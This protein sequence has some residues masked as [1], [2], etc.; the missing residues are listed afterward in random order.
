[1][2]GGLQPGPLSAYLADASENSR[3]DDGLM[4]RFQLA[5]YPDIQIQWFNVDKAPNEDARMQ[6]Y[7]AFGRLAH[8]RPEQLGADTPASGGIPAL[9]FSTEAQ[10]EFDRWRANLEMRLRSGTLTPTLESHLAKFRKLVPTLALLIHVI[11]EGRGPVELTALR[12]AV[13][14]AQFLESHAR[15]IYGLLTSGER[16]TL[17]H[18]GDALLGGVFADGFSARDVYRT[19]RSGLS[20]AKAVAAALQQLVDLGWLRPREKS[21]GG[22]PIITYELNP[23]IQRFRIETSAIGAKGSHDPGQAAPEDGYDEVPKVPEGPLPPD[24]PLRSSSSVTHG[25]LWKEE[26]Q[27]PG[28]DNEFGFL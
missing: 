3:L 23:D 6:A 7:R 2:L 19:H 12:K 26:E 16:S 14:W 27:P 5:V 10:K 20:D 24:A 13:A 4:Q 17:R 18:L 22:R 1:M 28:L 25:T 11:D 8:L 21:T 9:R 15:R